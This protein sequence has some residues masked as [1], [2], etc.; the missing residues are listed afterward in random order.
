MAQ[1]DNRIPR[2]E[3]IAGAFILLALAGIAAGVYFSQFD[4]NP[5]LT[6][7]PVP[8][9]LPAAAPQAP[10]PETA[11][12]SLVPVPEGMT[13]M[14]PPESFDR[15]TL[16]DK[17][18]GKADLYLSAGFEGLKCQRFAFAGDPAAWLEV[19]VFDMKTLR[20]AFAVY[21]AQR[22]E[23]AA[24]IDLAPYAYR[25]ANAVFF[26]WGP[27]YVEILASDVS[28]KLAAGSAQLARNFIAD[29]PVDEQTIP[30]LR[31]LPA[32]NLARETIALQAANVF[33]FDRLQ[34]VFVA[35][36]RVDGHDVPAF[37]A[38]RSSDEEAAA[39]A[40]SYR[41]FLIDNG[42]TPGTLTNSLS[43]AQLVDLDGV[44]E[45][46]FSRGKV[47]AGVHQA[48]NREAAERVAAQLM[49]HIAHDKE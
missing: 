17:V 35:E 21:S 2:S 38:L 43:G 6:A 9:P 45:I 1:A 37:V 23:D 29:A 16:S 39:L 31:L 8:P 14:S 33:G 7:P 4:M 36:Y 3:T 13:P 15:E 26:T 24:E 11:A 28:D 44:F 32:E 30:E 5:A 46:V 27:W 10:E 20:N 19:C 47:L 48:G 42:G 12:A 25:S 41:D 34:N 18:D 22:R 40:R 49:E